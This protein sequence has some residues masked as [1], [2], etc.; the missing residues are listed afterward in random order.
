MEIAEPVFAQ[1]RTTF[2]AALDIAGNFFA[3]LRRVERNSVPRTIVMK[4]A[5][6]VLAPGW[7]SFLAAFDLAGKPFDCLLF[8]EKSSSPTWLHIF[9][10]SSGFNSKLHISSMKCLLCMAA[11]RPAARPVGAYRALELP[12][13]AVRAQICAALQIAASFG[14]AHASLRSRLALSHL[15]FRPAQLLD[16]FDGRE[17]FALIELLPVRG[18]KPSALGRSI[19]LRKRASQSLVPAARLQLRQRPAPAKL[20]PM[21]SAKPTGDV[22]QA[23]V[24]E[25]ANSFFHR[26]AE[27]P[28]ITPLAP[29]NGDFGRIRE[30]AIKVP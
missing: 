29:P 12:P 14:R 23:A 13:E 18:A 2:L 22:R 30:S 11:G 5:E 21:A 7:S 19:A 15:R 10:V 16:G 6:P 1:R 24:R 28:F 8:V 9:G 3:K 27:N 17:F 25:L 20:V 26:Y 4:L